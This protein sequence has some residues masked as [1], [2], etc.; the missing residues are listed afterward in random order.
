M[1]YLINEEGQG[2]LPDPLRLSEF[3]VCSF[4]FA[5]TPYYGWTFTV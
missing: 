5:I 2:V 1:K 3:R 4:Y